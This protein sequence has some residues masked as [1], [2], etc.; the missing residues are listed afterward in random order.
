MKKCYFFLV[1]I[2]NDLERK[3]ADVFDIFDHAGTKNVDIREVGTIVRALGCCP[4]EAEVQEMLVHLENPA[5]PGNVPLSKFLPY[6]CQLIT[7][8]K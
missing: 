8:H 2:T 6:V 5:A 1:E 7:E 3:I 4:S